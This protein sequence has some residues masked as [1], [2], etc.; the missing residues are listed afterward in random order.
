M[1]LMF[2]SDGFVLLLYA[3][4]AA[5]VRKWNHISFMQP[6]A[7][8]LFAALKNIDDGDDDMIPLKVLFSS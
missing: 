1:N 7:R 2:E 4:L 6:V 5:S 8:C 3:S